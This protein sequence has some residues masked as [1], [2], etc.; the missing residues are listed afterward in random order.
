M[1]AHLTMQVLQTR[2]EK[3]ALAAADRRKDNL[4]LG[5][6]GFKDPAESEESDTE[7]PQAQLR[8]EMIASLTAPSV[9]PMDAPPDRLPTKEERDLIKMSLDMAKLDAKTFTSSQ[10]IKSSAFSTLDSSLLDESSLLSPQPVK[11]GVDLENSI[12]T[13]TTM[14]GEKRSTTPKNDVSRTNSGKRTPL[15]KQGKL[16][17]MR[18]QKENLK[19]AMASILSKSNGG[20]AGDSTM[21]MASL[22]GGPSLWF[23]PGQKDI[24]GNNNTEHDVIDPPFSDGSLRRMMREGAIDGEG[25]RILRKIGRDDEAVNVYDRSQPTLLL[26]NATLST[27]VTLPPLGGGQ[28]TE[29]KFGVQKDMYKNAKKELLEK[30]RTSSAQQRFSIASARI[31]MNVNRVKNMTHL[32]QPLSHEEVILPKANGESEEELNKLRTEEQRMQLRLMKSAALVPADAVAKARPLDKDSLSR[33]QTK[34]KEA[35]SSAGTDN[36][37]KVRTKQKARLPL[38][39]V[40]VNN[41]E[42]KLM[43][44][45]RG[46]YR[47]RVRKNRDEK[48]AQEAQR[49]ASMP[50]APLLSSPQQEPIDKNTA[51]KGGIK[52]LSI[53]TA[54]PAIQR[55]PSSLFSPLIGSPMP[56]QQAKTVDQVFEVK[57]EEDNELM[58]E[59]EEDE[60]SIAAA[61]TKAMRESVKQRRTGLTTRQLL[62]YYKLEAVHQFMDIFAKVDENFS[63]DID[64][65][66]WIQL[67]GSLGQSIPEQ[68]ARMIFMKID[69]DS[70]GFLSMRELVPVV[71]SKATYQQQKLIIQYT[72]L[73]LIKKIDENLIPKISIVE[74]EALFEAYDLGNVGYVDVSHIRERLRTM[75]LPENCLYA[76]MES[77]QDMADDEM[78]NLVEFKRILRMYTKK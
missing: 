73:E 31:E 23:V 35:N 65:N 20:G 8:A 54:A 43:Q 45:I 50:P 12:F 62:P 58:D 64:V 11:S 18:V 72:E 1:A 4:L 10:S 7:S 61:A 27:S 3:A 51:L 42:N 56:A 55:Q 76:F 70:D 33:W 5:F 67:F 41:L 46:E 2:K 6:K 66:E 29:I 52:Q 71:F 9:G 69:K 13:T 77:I 74:I 44:A 49:L 75:N 24:F 36:K 16:K 39:Q 40:A 32:I 30:D 17:A 57:E 14:N 47:A 19:T 68:E 25:M 37:Y 53:D 59:E 60:D 22:T 34:V 48:I 78:V 28:I 26:R 63:G 15:S 38:S 21:L